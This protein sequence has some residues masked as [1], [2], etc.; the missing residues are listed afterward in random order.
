VGTWSFT[1]HRPFHA[2]YGSNHR[3]VYLM[4]QRARR[5]PYLALFDGADPNRST[6]DRQ[7]TTT[8][9]QALYLMNAPFV[10]AQSAG[11]ARRLRAA[12][13]D[14]R[15]R[16]RLAYE[17]VLAREP[18]A[19]ELAEAVAF[20]GRYRARLP[21]GPGEEQAWAALGRVLMTSNA[22]LFVD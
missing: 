22:F 10:H 8:P 14:D 6:A 20:V 12:G 1:I 5:H 4:V 7:D 16:V 3:S 21:G 15:A 2:V 13:P 19:D 9:L 17:L 11:L 18:D